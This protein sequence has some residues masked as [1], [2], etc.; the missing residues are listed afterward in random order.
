VILELG[1]F[2][3]R[4]NR[5]FVAAL[6]VGDMELPSDVRGVAYIPY[7]DNDA[8]KGLLVREL[9][10]AGMPINLDAI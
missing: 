10:H 2:V 3:G 7:Q 8:W 5:D 9:R 1:Y 6:M 4:L